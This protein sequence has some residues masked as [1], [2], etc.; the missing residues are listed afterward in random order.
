ML[1]K[2]RLVAYESLDD[3][4]LLIDCVQCLVS[5]LSDCDAAFLQAKIIPLLR[6]L[7]ESQLDT[8]CGALLS[9]LPH[10]AER[11][12]DFFPDSAESVLT[13]VILPLLDDIAFRG[14]DTLFDPII[15]CAS[16]LITLL[17]EGAVL[18]T[19]FPMLRRFAQSAS[20]QLRTLTGEVLSV[21]TDFLDPVVYARSVTELLNALTSDV[22]SSVRKL[23]PSLISDYIGRFE[24][25]AFLCAR[26]SI[27]VR[28]SSARVRQAAAESLLKLSE[29]LDFQNR[30]VTV[31]P[32]VVLLLGDS[33]ATVREVVM[34]NLG[35]LIAQFGATVQSPL[36]TKYCTLLS[37]IDFSIAF[38]A[39]F[40]FPAVALALGKAR[41]PEVKRAFEVAIGAQDY[42]I[43]R[44]LAFGL[45]SFGPILD[46]ETLCGVAKDF[47]NDVSEVAVGI[48]TNL[49]QLVQY[50]GRK[51]ELLFCLLEPRRKYPKWRMR[52][53]VSE[54]LRYCSDDFDRAALMASATE[55]LRDDVAFVRNDAMLSFVCLMRDD[56]LGVL[57]QLMASSN[58]VDRLVVAAMVGYFD[59]Y[60][61]PAGVAMLEALSNDRV[62]SVRVCVAKSVAALSGQAADS[63]DALALIRQKLQGDTDPDV[64]ILLK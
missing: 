35:P 46:P 16:S 58:W 13:H 15:D 26:F 37:S 14:A 3:E 64:R 30:V 36:V 50:V 17:D 23:V 43:R 45:A 10:F 53:R 44:T 42:Q 63:A 27:L 21:L 18:G 4:F 57:A 40:A 12:F 49:Y 5:A 29:A 22:N 8:V 32:A 9:A 25:K 47:L 48:I 31:F 54:Q 28:D 34:K 55:L 52:L 33:R 39:A 41:W 59:D 2:D 60:F 6:K 61:V 24:R 1:P 11:L 56:D 20:I 7:G 51:E 19:A 62:A 38:S